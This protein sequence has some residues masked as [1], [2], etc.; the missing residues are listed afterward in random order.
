MTWSTTTTRATRTRTTRE[1]RSTRPT[2]TTRKTRPA[3]G[4]ATRA[5]V[6]A[7]VA[8]VAGLGL[9]A[10]VADPAVHVRSVADVTYLGLPAEGGEL[11]PAVDPEEHGVGFARGG[12]PQTVNVVTVGSSSCPLT[13]VD[14]EWDAAER[15]LAFTFGRR[16]ATDTR[17]CTLDVVPS[18]SVVHVDGLPADE[19]VTVLTSTREVVLPP[20]R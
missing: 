3:G 15:T 11:R 20:T 7:A 16:A 1:A 2:G 14:V 19:P 18:T 8:L 9:T 5:V 4:R 10:C 12:E 6:G 13:P 17:P